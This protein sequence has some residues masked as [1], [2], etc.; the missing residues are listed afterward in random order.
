MLVEARR[1]WRGF[2]N[3]EFKRVFA[4]IQGERDRVY[5]EGLHEERLNLTH[6]RRGATLLQRYRAN[7]LLKTD[8][9]IGCR[10]LEPSFEAPAATGSEK[11]HTDGTQ[12]G[13]GVGSF[14]LIGVSDD[15][16]VAWIDADER[17]L[18]RHFLSGVLAK[19]EPDVPCA[20]QSLLHA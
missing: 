16:N 9:T 14:G 19:H 2:P 1:R 4:A 5:A 8:G 3:R 20:G 17:G 6:D 18:A 7:C 15:D 11:D 13:D 12:R 10:N